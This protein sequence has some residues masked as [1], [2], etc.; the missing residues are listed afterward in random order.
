[1]RG[2]DHLVIAVP[3]PENAAAKL[4]QQL[5]IAFSA[6]GT[7]PDA[8][9]YNRIAFI[10]EPYIELIGIND[11]IAATRAPIGSAALRT[12]RALPAGGLATYALVD[13]DLDAT[14]ARLR[15]AGSN[16]GAPSRG[17]RLAIDGETIEWWTATFDRLAVEM[18]PFLI[19]HKRTGAEWGDEAVLRRRAFVQP[20]R[21]IARLERLVLSV[22]DPATLGA[23]YAAELGLTP[24]PVG[25]D[26]VL[27]IGPHSVRLTPDRRGV[28][29]AT[30]VLA[31]PGGRRRI[32]DLFSVRFE[33]AALTSERRQSAS[34]RSAR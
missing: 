16:I 13:D 3:D 18:P 4:E 32:V 27:T 6:G 30:I 10:G 24:E 14:V 12:L 20:A 26:Q 25:D 34:R 15:K 17:S 11:P 2:I 19:R 31:C 29:P 23:L 1:M 22:P 21:C 5:G 9:T 7:H 8:G 28:P 33:I